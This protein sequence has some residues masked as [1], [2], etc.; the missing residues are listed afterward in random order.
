M[1]ATS[2]TTL[3]SAVNRILLDTGERPVQNVNN[4]IARKAVSALAVGL[5]KL[6]NVRDWGFMRETTPAV[7]WVNNRATLPA[8]HKLFSVTYHAQGNTKVLTPVERDIF[9]WT[10]LVA[11][12]PDWYHQINESEVI[13]H[14]YPSTPTEQLKV[15]FSY[16]KPLVMPTTN[17]GVFPIP[18]RFMN[19][20][21]LAACAGFIR[22][23]LDDS[24][25]SSQYEQ[26][27]NALAG[28]LGRREI[29]TTANSAYR[30]RA[31][32][33]GW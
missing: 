13:F 10:Q 8:V 9:P 4:N 1:S 23:H 33:A 19:V 22:A 5:E 16:L 18:E 21:H 11:G 2:D 20:L 12:Y 6:S 15:L 26:E 17:E 30:L 31:N 27:F 29:S 14:P 32:R 3:L 7:S 25:A 28:S 24:Q